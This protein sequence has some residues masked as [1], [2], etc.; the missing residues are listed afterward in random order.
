MEGDPT[1]GHWDGV[2]NWANGQLIQPDLSTGTDRE[3]SL[4][5]VRQV[6]EQFLPDYSQYAIRYV[7]SGWT[8]DVY[9][10]NNE[11]VLRFP[12]RRSGVDSLLFEVAISP[13]LVKATRGTGVLV[14][15]IRCIDPDPAIQ[16]PYPIAIYR[17]LP[18]I[19]AVQSGAAIPN[20]QAYTRRLG[21]F[22]TRIHSIPEHTFRDVD[23]PTQQELYSLHWLDNIRE[24]Y[25]YINSLDEE[26][27]TTCSEWLLHS[28]NPPE[29]YAGEPRFIHNDIW[30]EHVLVDPEDGNVSAVIDW[31]DSMFGDPV[32]DF[33]PL[34]FW[35]G[36]EQTR[37]VVASYGLPLDSGFFRRLEFASKLLSLAWLHDESGRSDDLGLEKC[38]VRRAFALDPQ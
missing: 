38:F 3:L 35:I 34:P 13:S 27:F 28:A 9:C 2:R 36:W 32:S 17:Y 37:Q 31:E 19:S 29:P 20:W 22:M 25:E 1:P 6:A 26:G 30:P 24:M 8:N 14:P 7:G 12:R 11:W 5:Q 18:G 16:F 4:D 15:N 33:A 23:I 10:V 21:G